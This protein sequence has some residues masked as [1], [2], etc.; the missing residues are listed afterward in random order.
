MLNTLERSNRIHKG[1]DLFSCT[2]IS[3]EFK[4]V[5]TIILQYC[6]H[7]MFF[8]DRNV[9]HDAFELLEI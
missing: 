5:A 6:C 9:H 1:T 2:K 4:N 7:E 3:S 8:F